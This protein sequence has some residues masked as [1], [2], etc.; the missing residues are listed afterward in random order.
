MGRMTRDE[1]IETLRAHR[2][3]LAERFGVRSLAL[4]GS[5]ARGTAINTSDVDILAEFDAAPDW[6]RYFGAQAYLEEILG[7][8]VDFAMIGEIREEIRG[9]VKKDAISV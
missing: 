8:P 3:T 6:R 4:F 5:Y 1:V 9:Y 2:E 7:R